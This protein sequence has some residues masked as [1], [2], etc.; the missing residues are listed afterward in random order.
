[1]ASNICA[2]LILT[3]SSLVKLHRRQ[4]VVPLSDQIGQFAALHNNLTKV[5]GQA[6]TE[7]TVSKWEIEIWKD[8]AGHVACQRG[9]WRE[10]APALF[11]HGIPQLMH[12]SSMQGVNK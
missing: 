2:E 5:I 12:A 10:R 6:S 9:E 8:I 1:M 11:S 3:I 7:A 4:N